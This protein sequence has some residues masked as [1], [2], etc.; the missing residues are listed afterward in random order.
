MGRGTPRSGMGILPMVV[1]PRSKKARA[2]R[3][4]LRVARTNRGAENR[5]ER[6]DG[7]EEEKEEIQSSK[8]AKEQRTPS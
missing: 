2:Q 7:R 8:A 6:E 3:P 5:E 4:P 1:V